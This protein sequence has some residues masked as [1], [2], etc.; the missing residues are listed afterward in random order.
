ML[1]FRRMHGLQA[2]A[3]VHAAV[4]A[5][6]INRFDSARRLPGRSLF[7]SHRAAALAEWR[8]LCAG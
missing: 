8:D 2:F 6:V 5:A 7:K 3:A 4:H 1:R